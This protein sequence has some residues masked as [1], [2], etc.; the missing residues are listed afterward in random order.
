MRKQHVV[1]LR[2]GLWFLLLTVTPL[3]GCSGVLEDDAEAGDAPDGFA[4][5]KQQAIVADATTVWYGAMGVSQH[6][7]VWDLGPLEQGSRLVL[8]LDGRGADYDLGLFDQDRQ[9]L[10]INRDRRGG[11]DPYTVFDLQGEDLARLYVVVSRESTA[12]PEDGYSLM[13]TH[14]AGALVPPAAPQVVILNFSGGQSVSIG[15]VF[16]GVVYPF[17]AAALNPEWAEHTEDMRQIILAELER[18]YEGLDVAFRFGD[19]INRPQEASII[20]FGG[21]HPSNVGLAASVDYGNRLR[22]QVAIVYTENFQKYVPYGYTHMDIAHGLANVAAHEL[23]HLLGLNHTDLA[24]DVMNVSPTVAALMTPQYFVES[25]ALDSAVFPL[26]LQ[27]GAE[28]ILITVGG[29]WEQVVQS[30]SRSAA[31]YASLLPPPATRLDLS[32]RGVSSPLSSAVHCQSSH[33]D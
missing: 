4:S 33:G 11:R 25:A 18:I 20:Y 9:V 28:R 21:T 30:R 14:S 13:V 3:P 15:N 1:S 24:A 29:V 10:M 23:G 2:A 19:P 6:L 26:G 8:D 12:A 32:G 5:A 7:E 16:H 17:D 31:R 27:D 22:D